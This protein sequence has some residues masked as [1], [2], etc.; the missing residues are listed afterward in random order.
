MSGEVRK[1]LKFCSGWL[2]IIL[3]DLIGSLDDD[4]V[5]RT[6]DLL[7]SYEVVPVHAIYLGR[8]LVLFAGTSLYRSSSISECPM[9]VLF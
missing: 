2:G 7:L 6:A 3:R 9:L 5:F 4:V 8:S 1:D